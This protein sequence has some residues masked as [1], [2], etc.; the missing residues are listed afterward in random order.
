MIRTIDAS[1]SSSRI[2]TRR[3]IRLSLK[4]RHGYKYFTARRPL[5]LGNEV[6]IFEVVRLLPVFIQTDGSS[7]QTNYVII[8]G[9]LLVTLLK[10]LLNLHSLPSYFSRPF[11]SPGCSRGKELSA[12]FV[13]F[14]VEH[15]L[16]I[17]GRSRYM[18]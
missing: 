2:Y 7:V 15:L 8:H 13:H 6:L 17:F 9:S 11:F 4:K 10:F 3:I 5:A 18:S 16:T 1:R 12:H 14:V